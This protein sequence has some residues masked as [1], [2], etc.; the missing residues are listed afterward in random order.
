MDTTAYIIHTVERTKNFK[1]INVSEM[2][3]GGTL[4]V[5]PSQGKEEIATF[6]HPLMS[7]SR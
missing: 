3:P 1:K 6:K 4:M 2:H 5:S 7:N